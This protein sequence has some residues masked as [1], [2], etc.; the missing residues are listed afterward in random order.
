MAISFPRFASLTAVA[1]LA[2][3]IASLLCAAG[4]GRHA[5][6]ADPSLALLPDS[7]AAPRGFAVPD[8]A[9][10]PG[11]ALGASIRRGRALVLATRDSLPAHV[12]SRLACTNCH[13]DAGT[14]A[15]S[16]AWVGTF[17]TFPQYNA[18]AGRVITIEDRVNECMRR[19]LNGVPLDPNGRDMIDIVSYMAF[20]S[21]GMPQGRRAPWLGYRTLAPRTGDA[22]AGAR[23]FAQNCVRC[24]GTAGQG[25]VGIPPLWGPGSF[26]IGAGM[27]RV[28]TAA[29]F[30]R[31]NMPRDRPGTLTDQ[32]A[33]DVAAFVL[34]HPRPDTPGKEHDWP[35]GDAP[36]DAAYATLAGHSA[37]PH[38]R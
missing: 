4:C 9:R 22:G 17:A 12:S 7:V 21:S 28:R 29:A 35:N 30:I 24:H 27:S 34:S 16:S 14:R 2:L 11:G 31:W 5:P 37:G 26:A 13:L 23:V 3:P 36:M 33:Y 18:R 1:L 25:G 20:L 32:Q 15:G 6:P 8:S 38:R 19:S 10:I